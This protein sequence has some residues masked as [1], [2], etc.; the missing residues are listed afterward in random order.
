MCS[1]NRGNKLAVSTGAATAAAPVVLGKAER[2]LL[3]A[4]CETLYI[5]AADFFQ[6]EP[7]PNE[8]MPDCDRIAENA[9]ASAR[10][11]LM[12][13]DLTP[14]EADRAASGMMRGAADLRTLA[15]GA[16]EAAR[17]SRLLLIE[18]SLSDA[19]LPSRWLRGALCSL[20]AEAV[21]LAHEAATSLGRGERSAAPTAAA[22]L[23]E[24][25]A[26]A[27]K[28][29]AGLRASGSAPFSPTALRLV[30]ALIW[31]VLVAAESAARIAARIA[32][33]N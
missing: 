21:A 20:G 10:A 5:R 18:L 29:M 27:A 4:T 14:E 31:S 13:I 28:V 26:T 30:R 12:R 2:A 3:R 16:G 23:G 25:E 6:P 19:A 15:R 7:F 9:E 33:T 17:L 1:S 32:L 11:L 24:L 22:A 8:A